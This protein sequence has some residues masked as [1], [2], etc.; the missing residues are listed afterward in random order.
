MDGFAEEAMDWI[1]SSNKASQ[2][3]IN[4]F[5]LR[6]AYL[7]AYQALGNKHSADTVSLALYLTPQVSRDRH[8]QG[9]SL[10]RLFNSTA[11]PLTFIETNALRFDAEPGKVAGENETKIL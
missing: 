7:L 9:V 4:L 8:N 11:N 10:T 3:E 1:K 5:H 2:L 6:Q